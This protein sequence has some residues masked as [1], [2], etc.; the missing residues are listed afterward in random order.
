MTLAVTTL[1]NGLRVVTLATPGAET[2]ALGLYADTGSRFEDASINGIAHLFEHMVFKG[3]ATRSARTIAEAIEDVGGQLNAYT[4]RD[5]TAFHARV[6]G[7]DVP[8]AFELIADLIRAPR[9]DADDLVRE[10]DVVLSELG[11]ARDTPDDIVFD[12]LQEAAFPDQPLG[13]SILGSEESLAAIGPEHLRGWLDAQFRGPS[14]VFAA[15]GK[16]D[17][18]ALVR[19]AEGLLGDLPDGAHPDSAR[20]SFAGGTR[21]DRRKFEQAHLTFG[22]EAAAHRAPDYYP[23]TLFATAAGGGMSS[24]LFQELREERGLA[25][26][27]YATLTSYDDTG[28]FS[29]YLATA[30]NNAAAASALA[31]QVLGRCAEGLDAAELARAKAQLKAGLL[32]SLEGAAGWAE[33]LARQMLIHGAPVPPADVIAKVDAVTVEAARDAAQRMLAG[34]M[35][36]AHVGSIKLQAA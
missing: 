23:L 31:L 14:C 34:P 6:L 13:R 16:V 9:F 17:H 5:M 28:L 15:A 30:N 36:R 33:Y 26:S 7:D 25:Y 11:E 20:A 29:V 3:T 22:Y 12:H 21:H 19:M 1:A 4:A 8:L 32:M 27:V 24:R 2:A 18:D 35:A 10:K